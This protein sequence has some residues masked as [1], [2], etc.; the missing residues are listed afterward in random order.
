MHAAEVGR[1]RASANSCHSVEIRA[2][3]TANQ[4]VGSSTLSGRAIFLIKTLV[5]RID[6]SGGCPVLT[7]F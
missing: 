1:V 2:R 6:V 7:R 3:L 5:F 4:K